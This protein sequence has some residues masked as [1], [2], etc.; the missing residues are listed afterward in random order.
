MNATDRHA[1]AGAGDIKRLTGRPSTTWRLRVRDWR[2][3]FRYESAG[4]SIF[5]ERV[6]HRSQAYRLALALD[7]AWLG[8]RASRGG[9]CT[10]AGRSDRCGM[11]GRQVTGPSSPVYGADSRSLGDSARNSGAQCC[12]ER[13]IHNTRLKC[14]PSP[15]GPL[16]HNPAR[17]CVKVI[18]VVRAPKDQLATCYRLIGQMK[19]SRH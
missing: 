19:E 15:G 2:V 12:V 9:G 5:V 8:W 4:R 16:W 17:G 6:V 14:Q 11:P 1:R 13:N 18:S 7:S 3:F 10:K